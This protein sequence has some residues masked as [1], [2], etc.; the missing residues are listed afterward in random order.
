MTKGLLVIILGLV[1]FKSM[2]QNQTDS[3][4]GGYHHWTKDR[5]LLRLGTGIQKSFYYELGISRHKYIHNYYSYITTNY[6]TSTAWTPNGNILEIKAGYELNLS[7]IAI[8][9]EGKYQTNFE[10]NDFV[11]TPKIGLGLFGLLN[12][13]YGYNISTN[14]RPFV[15]IGQN[16]VSLAINFGKKY[17]KEIW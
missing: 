17:L 11:L 14:N 2:G 9:L 5:T 7:I 8:G 3:L 10:K 6:Y 13:F 15:N 4:A 1:S 16:Q 12:I